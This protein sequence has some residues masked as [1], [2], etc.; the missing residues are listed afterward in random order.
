MI[1][2][3]NQNLKNKKEGVKIE[4]YS[5]KKFKVGAAS[6]VIG[7]SIFFGAG[8]ASAAEVSGDKTEKNT[9]VEKV[10]SS[11]DG[12]TD[13]L[14]NKISTE[15]EV[16]KPAKKEEVV[17]D[18]TPT[19]NNNAN[20]D[21]KVEKKVLDK[22]TLKTNI[23]KVEELL[24]KINKDKA[25]ASTL[26]AIKIDL[27]NAKNIFNSIDDEL[28]QAEIDALVKKLSEKISVLSSMPKANTPEKV[29]K[30]GKNTIANSGSRD[31]RNGQ[32]MGEGTQFRAY[33]AT[34]SSGALKNV[35]YFA[36]VDKNTNG[37]S[38]T[39]NDDPEFTERKTVIKSKYEQNSSGKWMVYDV[40]FNN[41][42][43][44]MIEQS[45]GQHYYFQP[46]FNIMDPSNTVRDLTI[47]RYQNVDG[48]PNRK[49][50]DGGSGF[51]KFG[52]T[53][54]IT[55]PW[56]QKDKIF[57][58]DRRSMYDPNSGV[59]RENQ[60]WDVFKNN[61]TDTYLDEIVR[62]TD[63]NYTGGVSYTLGM[64][65]G[66]SSAPLAIHMTARVKLK[67]SLT[68]Q[69]AKAYGRV[70]AASV[71][72]GPT[73]NQSYIVGSLGTSLKANPD[74]PLDPIQGL[75]V[76]KTVGDNAGDPVNPV[77]SGYVRHKNGKSFPTG[78]NWTWAG[79]NSPS[80]TQAGVFKYT[81][82]ATYKDGSKSTDAGS[83]SDGT[84]TLIVKP[85]QPTITT[86]VANKKGLT[87]Q[88]ITVNVGSG[89]PN[90]SKVNIYDGNRVIGTGTTNGQTATVTVTG[91]LPGNPIT[92]ETVVNN[93][94][95]V[96]SVRSNPV[97][98]TEAPD[99]QPP[100]LA[101][102]PANQ[103]VVEGDKVTF[104]VTARDNKVVN[105]DGSDF[106]SK[107]GT[108][109]LSGKATNKM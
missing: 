85:K 52:E 71:T 19:V 96:T 89:V 44:S 47:T 61:K 98:P 10:N 84:V 36:S 15:K 92:A 64:E 37:G 12:N 43:V 55:D 16:V 42:G 18:T 69:E 65:V 53:I 81:S 34:S 31:S 25:P 49:L 88:Q 32:S 1:G 86:N 105:I 70:Y 108:R 94:G 8:V 67:D 73:T 58:G 21:K 48:N 68:E 100:T 50:S 82:I 95:T 72:S 30:E 26:A 109:L 27:E 35:R 103:T 9:D 22:N 60:K 46:P 4:S 62:K 38:D 78:M 79:N 7:A 6:V 66:K 76:T 5:I 75:T 107:Y 101:I 106:T 17:A 41:N 51:Q 11:T 83:G 33:T 14:N 97:T 90:G 2:K 45:Y 93:G 39:R 24:E 20:T 104:T 99:T 28:T 29:V 91:A 54:T 40:Y 77:S 63:G 56:R 23:E 13:V 87:N 74:A 57:A 59:T 102:T 3:N 80:T